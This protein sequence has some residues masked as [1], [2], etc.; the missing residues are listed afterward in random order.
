M[1]AIASKSKRESHE[2]LKKFL[3]VFPYEKP[4]YFAKLKSFLRN[5]S[6]RDG[7]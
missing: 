2:V 3:K 6:L 1:L 4:K 5:C 7:R